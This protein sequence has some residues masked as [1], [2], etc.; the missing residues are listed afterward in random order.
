MQRSPD[1]GNDQQPL[2][3]TVQGMG[4]AAEAI[5]DG[6]IKTATDGDDELLA[7][8]MAVTAAFGTAGHII[9]I[10]RALDVKRQ[11]HTIVDGSEVAVGMVMLVEVDDMAVFNARLVVS[12]D[13]VYTINIP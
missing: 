5:V 1:A 11:F 9:D 2:V 10:E 7:Q 6:D 8:V 13:F 4:L 3:G 12:P